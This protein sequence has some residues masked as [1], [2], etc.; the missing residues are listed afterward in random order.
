MIAPA[1]LAVAVYRQLPRL[2]F[3]GDD[4]VCLF[5][6][7]NEGVLRF[8]V[9]PFGGHV[10]VVR[11][12]A[13]YVSWRLFGL[14]AAGWGWVML[15]THALNVALLA[16]VVQR[17]A[18]RP[19]LAAFAAILWGTSPVNAGALGWYAVYGQVLGTTILLLLLDGVMANAGRAVTRSRALGWC[20]LGLAGATCFGTGIAVAIV[21]PLV[22]I[23]L[24]PS[25]RG[26]PAARVLLALPVATVVLYVGLLWL[27]ARV[28]PPSMDQAI[29]FATF[30]RRPGATL[31]MF[32]EL[33]GFGMTSTVLSFATVGRTFP[34]VVTVL[35]ALG[36][37]AVVALGAGGDRR[38]R[39]T[40]AAALL[41]AGA[42]YALVA[43]GRAATYANFGRDLAAAAA[44]ARYHYLAGVP[45]VLALG[46]AVDALA[47][48]PRA[49]R[50]VAGGVVAWLL[51]L[52]VAWA[53][54]GW[55]LELREA[56]RRWVATTLAT[57]A[58][59]VDAAPPGGTVVVEN[60]PA[61][62]EVLGVILPR[63][64]FPGAAALFIVAHSADEV[65]GRRVRFVER[66]AAAWAQFRASG[67]RLDA[68]LTGPEDAPPTIPVAP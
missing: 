39:R 63:A 17:V 7:A 12:L 35:G 6:M 43:I 68:L 31:A 26:T 5:E 60:R 40:I 24:D 28:G 33:V 66:D 45:L 42:V 57:I 34:G 56:P 36:Y 27:A 22:A 54:T 41:I 48:M 15:L 29:L 51:F 11:N 9:R 1:L 52:A 3:F 19:L 44:V 16:R 62:L 59:S 4:F 61:P 67:G 18:A 25:L 32:V 53:R 13:M 38:H 47:A 30:Y 58:A 46:V 14:D 49:G 20:A 55:R 37:V 23:L 65:R 8:V 2:Y 21:L 50:L 10:L 64:A